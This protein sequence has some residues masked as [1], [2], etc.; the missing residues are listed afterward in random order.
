MTLEWL[1][2]QI[3]TGFTGTQSVYCVDIDGDDDLDVLGAA[4]D[5]D[6][7]ALWKNIGEDTVDWEYQE[8]DGDFDF[9]HWVYAADMNNDFLYGY[10]W[11]GIFLIAK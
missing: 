3:A 8:I 9:A 11:G 2:D 4:G 5:L 1:K 10:L 7:I 6:E